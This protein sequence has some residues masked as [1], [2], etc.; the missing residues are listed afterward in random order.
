M[1]EFTQTK[2][3]NSGAENE[4][5]TCLNT[6]VYSLRQIRDKYALRRHFKTYEKTG[7]LTVPA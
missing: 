4:A 3:R 1:R 6:E 5:A 7:L 2:A